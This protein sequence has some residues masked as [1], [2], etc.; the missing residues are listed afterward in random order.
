VRPATEAG[1]AGRLPAHPWLAA[2]EAAPF[3]PPA[4]A[5]VDRA[6]VRLLVQQGLVVDSGDGFY[7]ASALQEAARVVARLLTGSP[8]GVTTSAVREALGTNRRHALAILGR[9]DATGITRRLGDL[10]VGGPRLPALD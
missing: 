4:P 7:A 9:L 5:G 10:R 2:L 6:D 1:A 8:A 3:A